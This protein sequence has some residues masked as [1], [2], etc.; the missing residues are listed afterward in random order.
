MT[1]W[2]LLAL[3]LYFVQSLLPVTFRYRGSPAS[4]LARDTM[5]ETTVRVGRAER[6]L[7]N[8]GEAMILFLP[9]AILAQAQPAAVLGA[10]I[11]VL[12]RV[13]YVPLYLF[14]VP[15]FRTVVWIVSLYGL[16]S[17]AKTLF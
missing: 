1:T 14:G 17:I 12:A 10:Q 9:L 4:L 7:V 3:A 15:Y 6:A 13:V 5:P 8:I 11:F 16:W 2:I